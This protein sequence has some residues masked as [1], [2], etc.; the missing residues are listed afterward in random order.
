M[1]IST[2]ANPNLEPY[3]KRNPGKI[4]F[5]LAKFTQCEATIIRISI[6]F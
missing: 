5:S 6:M 3:K 1:Q 2:V 4:S